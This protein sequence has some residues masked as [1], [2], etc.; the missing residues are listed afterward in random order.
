[1]KKLEPIPEFT[2]EEVQDA[3]NRL[4]RG[5][6]GD[7]S[8]IKAEHVKRCKSETKEWITQ[9]LDEIVQEQECT[10]QAW[11]RIRIQVIHTKGDVE[12]AGNYRP[13]CSFK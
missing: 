12:E 7:S 13:I 5:K 3:I 1:M 2:T 6:A 8:G 11:S 10:P 9:I 4:K